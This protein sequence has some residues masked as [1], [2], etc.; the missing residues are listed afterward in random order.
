MPSTRHPLP[1][2]VL[3]DLDGT[4]VDTEPLWFA[5][6]REVA[7]HYGLVWGDEQSMQMVGMP[8]RVYGAT[9]V[10]A[11][12]Q[13]EVSE[14]V[15]AIVDLVA[16]ELRRHVTW[17]PGARELL[18]E[19]VDA[20]VPTALVT[21]SYRV[22]VEPVMRA[23]PEGAFVTVVTGEDVRN[24][25][26]DPEAYLRAAHELGVTID[27][28]VAIEDSPPGVGSALSA[29]ARTLGVPHLLALEPRP[30]LSRAHT[31]SAVTVD[32]L[33]RIAAGD[34]LD[35]TDRSGQV[36]GPNGP[37]RSAR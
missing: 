15:G 10:E 5:A 23:A 27:E 6:E 14:V 22:L 30:G 12:A 11:G 2:A 7:A 16:G 24:G 1:A 8:L 37:A 4:L 31:L 13:A 33:S 18:A 3:W 35:L 20:G 34:V 26:P 29:G 21:M 28:C 19:V 36:E 32:D 9:L 25:K 17:R